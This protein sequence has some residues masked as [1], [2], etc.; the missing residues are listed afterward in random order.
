MFERRLSLKKA[1]AVA[2]GIHALVFVSFSIVT[3]KEFYPQSR[4]LKVSLVSPPLTVKYA[5]RGSFLPIEKA[6][7]QS[8][9]QIPAN[10]FYRVRK[11][12]LEISVRPSGH[13]A[14]NRTANFFPK[15]D[16]CS[17]KC[18]LHIVTPEC[19]YWMRKI[20][21]EKE[22]K[23][24]VHLSPDGR[25]S[26]INLNTSSGNPLLDSLIKTAVSRWQFALPYQND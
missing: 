2:F 7:F 16:V 12:I 8:N 24:K 18:G 20:A 14:D 23:L 4:Y 1:L 17:K 15:E 11:E 21:V 9:A 6:S 22:I 26:W 19:H 5:R 10:F 3:V 13:P 25:V